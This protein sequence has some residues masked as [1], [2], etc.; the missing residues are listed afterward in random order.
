MNAISSNPCA[1]QGKAAEC[2]TAMMG[3][4]HENCGDV[5]K[6]VRNGIMITGTHAWL[7][8]WVDRNVL[9]AACG[10]RPTDMTA[11]AFCSAASLA[12][13]GFF[14]SVSACHVTK[15]SDQ[16]EALPV[17]VRWMHY[18]LL[19]A[20]YQGGPKVCGLIRMADDHACHI[21]TSFAA[22]GMLNL[23]QKK[24]VDVHTCHSTSCLNDLH[25]HMHPFTLKVL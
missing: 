6:T 22:S 18:I 13:S 21:P 16:N 8:L 17:D 9:F 4:D 15:V 3:D 2:G 10:Q 24:K 1:M 23:G 7:D 20:S 14:S 5:S 19:A 12:L 25:S 11:V